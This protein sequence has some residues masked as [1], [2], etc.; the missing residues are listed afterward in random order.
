MSK[1]LDLIR[2]AK[3]GTMVD[4]RVD[5]QINSVPIEEIRAVVATDEELFAR[6]L[7]AASK[8][9][10]LEQMM[11]GEHQANAEWLKRSEPDSIA[12]LIFC[13]HGA[14]DGV[15]CIVCEGN[16]QFSDNTAKIRH[17]HTPI[18]KNTLDES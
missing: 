7:T 17:W 4:F 11:V 13:K 14:V 12:S 6:C 18:W 3:D 5:N 15:D 16:P 8:P 1:T 10:K 2:N 9:S